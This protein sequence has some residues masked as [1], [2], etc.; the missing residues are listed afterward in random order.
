MDLQVDVPGLFDMYLVETHDASRE[1][2]E[3][4]HAKWTRSLTHNI[5]SFIHPF[6]F[7]QPPSQP[8]V[9]TCL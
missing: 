1:Y 6:T 8:L 4:R 5:H 2:I 9:G 7:A 3:P